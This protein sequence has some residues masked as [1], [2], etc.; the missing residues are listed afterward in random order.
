MGNNF[1]PPTQEQLDR[2]VVK[3]KTDVPREYAAP[4][5][6]QLKKYG[7]KALGFGQTL[8][9]M[10]GQAPGDLVRMME[11]GVPAQARD[12][13]YGG[14]KT[15]LT[16]EALE[17]FL[18]K[19]PKSETYLNRLGFPEMGKYSV[20]AFLTREYKT[21]RKDLPQGGVEY[22]KPYV[23]ENPTEFTG[24]EALGKAMDLRQ[25]IIGGFVGGKL[26]REAIGAVGRGLQSAGRKWFSVPYNQGNEIIS[27]SNVYGG[28]PLDEMIWNTGKSPGT[29]KENLRTIRN[30]FSS[31]RGEKK[32]I[33]RKIR[34]AG[35]EGNIKEAMR[36]AQ[37]HVNFLNST[38]IPSD[39]AAAKILQSDLN[40]LYSALSPQASKPAIPKIQYPMEKKSVFG[41]KEVTSVEPTMGFR[42]VEKLEPGPTIYDQPVTKK[43]KEPFISNEIVTTTE[44]FEGSYNKIRPPEKPIPAV[45]GRGGMTGEQTARLKG[46]VSSTIPEQSL[47]VLGPNKNPYETAKGAGL[48]FHLANMAEAAEPGLGKRML[49]IGQ[50]EQ[51]LIAIGDWAKAQARKEAGM[52]PGQ[53]T[54]MA[55]GLN[56]K[57]AAL[58]EIGRA[59]KFPGFFTK[60]GRAGYNLGVNVENVAPAAELF[61]NPWMGLMTRS[62]RD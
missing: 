53:V 16:K 47:G 60:P 46:Q 56:P 6:E 57:I 62:G 21:P 51:S 37:D 45:K 58:N 31:Y 10:W 17:A 26:A 9:N 52:R 49:D 7:K 35:V 40:E 8:F 18:G 25:D 43:Y 55:A 54:A 2:L 22:G 50:E 20:P 28:V 41:Q 27:Q 23:K 34:E 61:I 12:V 1:A 19:A 14:N 33:L 44:P 3:D 38:G 29:Q 48:Q 4:T 30:M 32:D 39:E 59:S 24:R 5:P 13:L 11:L 36:E 42:D 15:Q